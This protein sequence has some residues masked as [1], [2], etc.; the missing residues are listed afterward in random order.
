MGLSN[1]KKSSSREVAEGV[2]KPWGTD[3][4]FHAQMM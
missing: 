3:P 1:G 2:L 4:E